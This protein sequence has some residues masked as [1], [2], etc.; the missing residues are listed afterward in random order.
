MKPRYDSRR[1]RVLAFAHNSAGLAIVVWFSNYLWQRRDHFESILRISV[2][3][4]AALA[5]VITVT[6]T[7]TAAQTAV[8][9]R[10]SGV[11]IAFRENWL[12]TVGS[13]FG[14]YLPMLAGTVVRFHYMKSIHGLRYAHSGSISWL[15]MLLLTLSTAMFGLLGTV[16]LAMTGEPPSAVLLLL[17]AALLAIPVVA[18]L[19]SGPRAWLESTRRARVLV[20]FFEGLGALRK[21]RKN[22]LQVFLLIVSQQLCLGVRFAIAA[23]A[24]GQSPSF[25]LLCILAPLAVFISFVAITP[26]ALGLREAVIGYATYATG[27][28][29]GDGVY[30]ATVDRAVLL[31]MVTVFGGGSLAYLWYKIRR[32]DAAALDATEASRMQSADRG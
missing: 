29:F 13:A 27:T 21:E 24:T 5:L 31:A 8:L 2:G 23:Q 32:A 10:A 14:S 28:T 3:H 4:V 6:W 30:V 15:R 25:L 12:L 22:S 26:A 18:F 17:F 7:L 9:Y 20:S 1:K 16:G 11:R 19:W